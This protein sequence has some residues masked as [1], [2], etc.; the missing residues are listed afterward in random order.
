M[1]DNANKYDHADVLIVQESSE[2]ASCLTVASQP[3]VPGHQRR[4]EGN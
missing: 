4:G 3:L 1:Q 2:A